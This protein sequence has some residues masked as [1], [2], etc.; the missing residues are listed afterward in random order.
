MKLDHIIIGMGRCGTTSLSDYIRQHPHINNSVIKEVHYFSIDDHY[1]R[2]KAF[3]QEHFST[4]TGLQSTSDTYLLLSDKGPERVLEHNPNIKITVLLRD[5]VSRTYSNYYYSINNGYEKEN[6]GL[7]DSL[8]KEKQFLSGDIILKNNLCHFEGSLYYKL[9]SKWLKHFDKS[10]IQ[11]LRTRDLQEN[12][13]KVMDQLSS[14]LAVDPFII[15]PLTAQ[16]KAKRV[17]SKAL[18][19]FLLNRDHW[20]RN[21]IRRP[22]Q[23]KVIKGFIIRSRINDRISLMNKKHG[24]GYPTISPE[25]KEFCQDYFKNDLNKLKEHFNITL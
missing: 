24:D 20:L 19:Q 13:Q 8:K 17:K 23:I 16:N 18:Q 4:T 10:Q 22:L 25:E 14:F 9:L 6:T 5:P 21:L 7:V 12:P 1:K 15:T 2:G 11:I 3:L